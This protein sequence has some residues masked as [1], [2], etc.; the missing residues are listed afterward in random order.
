MLPFR[1][2]IEIE[3][4]DNEIFPDIQADNLVMEAIGVIMHSDMHYK[5]KVNWLQNKIDYLFGL[6]DEVTK[7]GAVDEV[8]PKKPPTV[9]S[10]KNSVDDIGVL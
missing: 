3:E 4:E 10:S 7:R 6:R 5:L 1:F 8:L 9:P 2:K